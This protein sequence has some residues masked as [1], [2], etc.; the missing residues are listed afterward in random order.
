MIRSLLP[1]GK[2]YGECPISTSDGVRLADA[3]WISTKARL[4]EIGRNVCLTKAPEICIEILSPSNT[5]REMSEKKA[6]YFAAGAEEVWFCDAGGEMTF[7][8]NA[9][10]VGDKKSRLCPEFPGTVRLE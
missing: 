2:C 8:V 4:A 5:Q 1:S 3:A 9:G 10:S 6:L 7:Y